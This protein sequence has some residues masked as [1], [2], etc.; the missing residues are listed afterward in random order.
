MPNEARFCQGR[1]VR[2]VLADALRR[3]LTTWILVG[4]S[5][6]FAALFHNDPVH[7]MR[8]RVPIAVLLATFFVASPALA[9]QKTITGRVTTEQGSPM[10][11][12]SVV[13]KGTRTGTMTNTQGAYTIRADVGQT[14]QFRYLGTAPEERIVGAVDVI[15]VQLNRVPTSMNAVVVT[16]LGQEAQ[17]RTLG[18]AQQTIGGTTV[19]E[20]QR[21]NFVNSLEGRV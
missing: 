6:H 18:A 10:A 11:G 3:R 5:R 20:A 2:Y 9:Q 15:D 21:D 19:A 12:A 4:S 7:S 13:V 16:A 1:S 17:V 14:L 8:N